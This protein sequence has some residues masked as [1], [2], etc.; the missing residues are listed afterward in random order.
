MNAIQSQPRN[1]STLRQNQRLHVGVEVRVVVRRGNEKPSSETT[2]TLI[3]S[4]N[5]ASIPLSTVVAVGEILA[6]RNL[7]TQQEAPCRVVDLKFSDESE[8][9]EV[10]IEFIEPAPTFWSVFF[11]PGGWNSRNAEAKGYVPRIAPPLTPNSASLRSS[12]KPR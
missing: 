8:M 10:E 11:P 3:V 1:T 7:H 5:G 2:K 9:T 12:G 6:V 4:T